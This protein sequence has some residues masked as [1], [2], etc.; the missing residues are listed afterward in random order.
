MRIVMV[1]PFGLRPKR[2]MSERALPLA[3]ALAARGH[4]VDMVLPSWHLPADSG[5]SWVEEG[6]TIYNVRLPT[7]IPGVWHLRVAASMLW[8]VLALNPDVVH[9]FKPK[10]YSGLVALNL[11][12]L[13]YLGVF[14]GRIVIDSDDWEGKG[15]WNEAEGY[16]GFQRAVF[17]W[18]ERWG[19]V[20]ADAVTVASRA[21]ETLVWS[22]GVAPRR[23]YYLPNGNALGELPGG[24]GAWVRDKYALGD[25]PIILLYTRFFEFSIERL[26]EIV[27]RV[28]ARLPGARLLVV[29]QGLFGEEKRLLDLA[30]VAD[31]GEAVVYAGWIESRHLPDYF[32]ASDVAIYPYDDTLINR[33]KCS[34]KL[35]GLLAAGL[36]V[37]ADRVG[38]NREYI[39]DGVSGL[40]VEDGTDGF[41]NAVVRLLG[42]AELRRRL[43]AAAQKRVRR[44]FDWGRLAAVVE[45][46][47]GE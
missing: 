13:Q 43:G 26:V 17:D 2:T 40:L 5:K 42:D 37:V 39:E 6:V 15:G 14:R 10:A 44:D 33:T 46:A 1:G 31:L 11:R 21:L 36:P 38:Q 4:E 23:V 32:A 24:D 22:L 19:L 30:H 20:H 35:V 45:G 9:C 25:R 8:R 34:V 41:A 3:K 29:G 27:R 16:S 47:Y 12:W 18:Q 28:V 7:R